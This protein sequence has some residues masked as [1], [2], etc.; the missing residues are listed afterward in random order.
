MVEE[1]PAEEGDKVSGTRDK[2]FLRNVGEYV[3]SWKTVK[4]KKVIIVL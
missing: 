3:T 4:S 2:I 1:K